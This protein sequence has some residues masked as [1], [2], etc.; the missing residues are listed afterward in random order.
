[1][2]GNEDAKKRNKAWSPLYHHSWCQ[3]W[4]CRG[5][6][7][8]FYSCLC[9]AAKRGPEQT[10]D[11]RGSMWYSKEATRWGYSRASVNHCLCQVSGQK[12][13]LRPGGGLSQE[14]IWHLVAVRDVCAGGWRGGNT[15]GDLHGELASDR[16]MIN[17]RWAAEGSAWGPSKMSQGT[18]A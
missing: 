16:G 12:V 4:D 10:Q 7:M 18:E 17:G 2:V 1:M 5:R 9:P 14:L 13:A 11:Q 15:W 6:V 3:S 8:S